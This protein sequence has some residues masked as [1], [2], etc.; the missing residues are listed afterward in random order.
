M[1]AHFLHQ[2]SIPS[3][4]LWQAT[5]GTLGVMLKF[6]A[7]HESCR[8]TQDAK[9]IEVLYEVAFKVTPKG[10][11]KKIVHSIPGLASKC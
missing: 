11:H 2:E 9:K 3:D 1:S 4:Y 10:E 8:K 5:C 7:A 6:D